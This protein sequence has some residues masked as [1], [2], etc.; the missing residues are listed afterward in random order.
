MIIA[1]KLAVTG[2]YTLLIALGIIALAFWFSLTGVVKKEER[3]VNISYR[4]IFAFF[5]VILFAYSTL[6]YAFFTHD[7]SISYVARYS[8][9]AM[10]AFYLFC[11]G[12]GGQD[13]S[14]LFWTLLAS[15]YV[16]LATWRISKSSARHLLGPFIL[17]T[18][19]TLLFFIIVTF[20][21]A[22]PFGILPSPPADG[23]G[24]NPLLQTP[25]MALHPPNL[26]LGLLGFL[27]PYGLAMAALISGKNDLKWLRLA[28]PWT[29]LAWA[30]LTIGNL[31][32]AYWAYT[33]L[34]WGGF[35]A[36]D[37][38]ENASFLPWLLGT[39][40]LHSLVVQ[41]RRAI[42]K[43]WTF[44]LIIMTFFLCIFGTFLT[45]S[46]LI[47]SVHAFA[48]SD[49]GEYFVV[50][51]AILLIFS[52]GLLFYRRKLLRSTGSLSSPASREASFLLNNMLLSVATFI[53]FFGTTYPLYKEWLT[54][55][56]A[57]V[58][59]PF[60]NKAM[61]PVALVFLILMGLSQALQWGKANAQRIG[62]L[63]LI[64]LALGVIGGALFYVYFTNRGPGD[65]SPFA[66]YISS[67]M[68]GATLFAFLTI[69]A[70][71]IATY[72]EWKEKRLKK[73]SPTPLKR[74]FLQY[75][76]RY[77]GYIVHIGVLC[78]F[79]GFA[80]Y[81]FKLETETALGEGEWTVLGNYAVKFSKM[82]AWEDR[83]KK[84][85]EADLQLYRAKKVGEYSL[86]EG[87][88]IKLPDGTSL[89]LVSM[90]KFG[91]PH[92]RGALIFKSP[93]GE[94]QRFPVNQVIPLTAGALKPVY[95]GE[96]GGKLQI[97]LAQY[98]GE[99]LLKRLLP[100]R[101][102]HF[103]HPELTTEVSLYTGIA[104]D[105]YSILVTWEKLGGRLIAQFKFYINP[106][107]FWLWFGGVIMILGAAINA[108]PLKS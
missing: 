58:G 22:D 102:K 43:P 77:G 21:A 90:T 35:W 94:L 68:V 29:I 100:A 63:L 98:R 66:A 10:P 83:Q 62:K 41:E 78:L 95:L 53:V 2:Q 34:G 81:V 6:I 37:P 3:L 92:K 47:T 14:L 82:Q 46:G 56:K 103:K 54:G 96:K 97:K 18:S 107:I 24:L 17:V 19:G 26:Y 45:R 79:I 48:R 7:F 50:F 69:F 27:I 108:V 84:I 70:D 49:I 75:R 76:R 55:T 85:V 40:F 52:F 1:S 71:V 93:T 4:L 11:A 28:R 25:V 73:G 99:K 106:L 101:H 36:W 33:E 72:R 44:S 39:A 42:L 65:P 30:F 8:E 12:W 31:L 9:R 59:P 105:F 20:F 13:G 15:I 61:A 86:T 91:P 60:F 23:K 89:T 67:A 87:Q 32:G 16:A 5:A 38:V 74:F 51:M 57:S 88:E 104:S 64:P 80:G